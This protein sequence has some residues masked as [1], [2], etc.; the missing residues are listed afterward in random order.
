MHDDRRRSA[1]DRRRERSPTPVRREDNRSPRR[2]RTR[3]ISP[4]PTGSSSS[5]ADVLA[6]I[7]GLKLS[8]DT[9]MATLNQ[10]FTDFTLESTNRFNHISSRVDGIND[11]LAMVEAER[12]EGYRPTRGPAP[13]SVPAPLPS[14]V[15]APT[16]TPP[17]NW[18]RVPDP[19]I[20]KIEA[21]FAD[22]SRAKVSLA[23]VKKLLDAMAVD[24]G[25]PSDQYKFDE[26]ELSDFHILRF[27][28]MGHLAAKQALQFIKG[29]KLSD[30][31]FRDLS[32][33]DPSGTPAQL[34]LNLDKNGR[35]RKTEGATRRLANL[36]IQHYPALKT[37]IFPRR[38][39]GIV[40]C[41][42]KLLASITV[43]PE[44]T[45]LSW[46]TKKASLHGVDM[47]A[48]KKEFL[49]EENITWGS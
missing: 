31:N 5:Q 27:G 15:P 38:E 21:K 35:Q 13:D 4:L 17:T 44:S 40:N 11:R 33:L 2:S 23:E 12:E 43:S 9:N 10:K 6:A 37:K 39:E 34:F 25:I 48:I 20:I 47:E 29:T 22:K 14:A 18:N 46:D 24:V 26:K 42:F 45:T 7:N 36:V 30:G 19:T 32:L 16:D 28:G 3:S 8:V 41:S 1:D 49:E